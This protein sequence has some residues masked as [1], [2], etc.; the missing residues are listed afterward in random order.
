MVLKPRFTD[1][2]KNGLEPGIAR[3]QVLKQGLNGD[4]PL[5]D[6]GLPIKNQTESQLNKKQLIEGIACKAECT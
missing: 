4:R 2:W 1:S 5:R 6:V 3:G